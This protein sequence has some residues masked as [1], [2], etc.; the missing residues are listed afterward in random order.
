MNIDAQR[1]A[2]MLSLS[3]TIPTVILAVS[4]V[5]LWLPAARKAILAD[6]RNAQQWF[7]LGVVAG[8]L[9]ST[10]DNLYW[11]FPWSA[12]YISEQDIFQTLVN[13]GVYFNIIFRQGFGILAAYCHVRAAASTELPK[14][15]LV[16]HLLV[17]SY[18]LGIAYV[19]LMTIGWF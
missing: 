1:L 17:G 15:R 9:G 7:I 5:Y 3:M 10:V 4:V 18:A 2:E 8:F 6:N 16:N 13:T 14:V 11:L 12:S 19:A